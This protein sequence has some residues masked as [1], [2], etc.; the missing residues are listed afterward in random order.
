MADDELDALYWAP[1]DA[2]TAERTKLAKAAKQRGD[3]AAAKRISAGRKPTTAAWIVNRLAI[4]DQQA[5]TRIAELGESLRAAHAAMDGVQIRELSARQHTLIDELT[6]AAIA[7]AEVKAPSSALRDDIAGTLQAAVADPDVRGRLGR[8]AKAERWSG[9]GEFGDVAAVSPTARAQRQEAKPKP[10]RSAG[11]PQRDEDAEAARRQQE[12]LTTAV[13]AAERAQA[14]ADRILSA[15]RA[16][17][18]TAR[19]LRDEALATLR[20]AERELSGAEK[21]YE[22]AKEASQA[23]EEWVKEAVKKAGLG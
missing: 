3:A 18:D 14:K 17:R 5:R 10:K 9:F 22:Q 23:A 7:T 19:Q 11:A 4:G 20:A 2:F 13:A 12:K 16:D 1:P 15:R 8:L 21:R 6:R